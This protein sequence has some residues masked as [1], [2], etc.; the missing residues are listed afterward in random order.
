MNNRLSLTAQAHA[1]IQTYL[2]TGDIAIDATLGNGHDTLFLAKQVGIH[3]IIFGFDVQQQALKATYSRLVNDSLADNIKLFHAS[4]SV[5]DAY[6]PVQYHTQIK[7]IIFNLGYLPGSD[8]VITTQAKSTLIALQ[9]STRLLATDGIISII[10]YPGHSSGAI[11]S[12]HLMQWCKQLNPKQ[13]CVKIIHSSDII[14]APR[15]III[16][17][18]A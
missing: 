7:A 14:T 17:K 18:L 5:M 9:K 11:E 2:N 3:G 15:L 10:A 16:N 6:I 1:I 13:F 8:K 4:H 12:N